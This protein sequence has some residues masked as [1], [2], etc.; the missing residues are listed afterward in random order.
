MA[1]SEGST[2]A[3]FSG[4]KFSMFEFLH[5]KFVFKIL[6]SCGLLVLYLLCALDVFEALDRIIEPLL[7]KLTAHNLSRVIW[8]MARCNY[9]PPY[10]PQVGGAG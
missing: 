4:F 9:N 3:S 8:A 7:W 2:Q 6:Y 5:E 10:M 1:S